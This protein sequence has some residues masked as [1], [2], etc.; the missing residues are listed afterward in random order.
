MA[1]GSQA[2][3]NE[4]QVLARPRFGPVSWEVPGYGQL[5]IRILLPLAIGLALYLWWRPSAWSS[6]KRWLLPALAVVLALVYLRLPIDVVPDVGAIGLLDDLLV[7][8]AALWWANQRLRRKG[9]AAGAGPA[10]EADSESASSEWDPYA[11]LQVPRGASQAEITRA[12]R[13]QMKR[14]HP[15]RVSG[16]GEELQRVAHRK[17]LEIQRAYQELTS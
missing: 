5:M 8:L 4:A 2:N 14:Y 12:Y 13:E 16:L 10:R 3:A 11:V 17:A 15:D 7:L 1:G 9:T 6:I